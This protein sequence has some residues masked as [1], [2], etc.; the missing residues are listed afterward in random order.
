MFSFFD[1]DPKIVSYDADDLFVPKNKFV[2]EELPS[3]QKIISGHGMLYMNTKYNSFET[4]L[5]KVI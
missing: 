1:T 5:I 4:S 3:K 2:S